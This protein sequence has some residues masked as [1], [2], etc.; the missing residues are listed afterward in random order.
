M[1]QYA[2]SDGSKPI[3]STKD[4]K[5][6]YVTTTNN[7][8]EHDNEHHNNVESLDFEMMTSFREVSHK[9]EDANDKISERQPIGQ[10]CQNPFF[11]KTSYLDDLEIQQKFLTPKSSNA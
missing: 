8:N 5:T 9:R 2:W 10:K 3:K 11:N 1:E 6:K 4:D 7:D